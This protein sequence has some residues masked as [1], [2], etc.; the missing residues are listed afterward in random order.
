[1]QGPRK[2]E[3]VRRI[4]KR[5]TKNSAKRYLEETAILLTSCLEGSSYCNVI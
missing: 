5:T 2:L 1:M 3:A 4:S